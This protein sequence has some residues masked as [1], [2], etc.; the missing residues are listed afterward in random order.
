MMVNDRICLKKDSGL[1]RS[2]D[3]GAS[4]MMKSRLVAVLAVDV[5]GYS[6]LMSDNQH[7]TV[8]GL[9][10]TRDLF[11]RRVEAHGGHI[12]DF[13]GD[14]ILAVFDTVVG[15]LHAAMAAQTE[16]GSRAAEQPESRRMLLRMG[17]HVGDIIEKP[18][19][20]V[21]GDAINIAAR[22]EGLAS[23]GGIAVSHEVVSATRGHQGL[24]FHDYGEFDFKN[25]DRPVRVYQLAQK[26]GS[27]LAARSIK[28]RQRMAKGNLPK[29][30]TGLVGRAETLEQVGTMLE[31]GRLV[32]L[33]GMG[34]MG[35]TRLA[36]EAAGRAAP[37][38]P[39]GAWFAD[40]AAV[41]ETTAVTHAV[42]G[43]FGVI[44]QHGKSIEQALVDAL[45]TQRVL[46][47]LDNCEHVTQAAAGLADTLLSACPHVR[48]IAT[49]REALS[50]GGEH[51]CPLGPL[52]TAGDE[53]PAVDLFVERAQAAVPRFDPAKHRAS[54]AQICRVLDGIPL[55][56]ELAAARV[57]SL[58]PGQI[59]ARL[60]RRFSLL[61]GGSRAVRERHQTLLNAVQWSYDLLTGPERAVLVRATVF[62]GG[63]SLE[64]VEEVCTGGE[65]E[66]SDVIDILDSLVRKSLITATDDGGDVRYGM[67]ET[68]RAFGAER[69]DETEG[70]RELHCAHARFYAADADRNFA[71]WRS[72]QQRL[73]HEWLD[74]EINNLRNAFRWAVENDC[75]DIAARIGSSVG[76]LGRFRLIEEAANW[77]EQIVDRARET[78]H[79]RLTILLTWSSSSAWAFQRFDDAQRFGEE[80]I[81]LLDDPRFEP[82]VWAYGD[83]AFIAIF[84]GDIDRAIELLGL[85]AGHPADAHDRFIMAFHLF[86]MATT[87]QQ[88]EA[89][90]IADDVVAKV[91]AA[92]VPMSIGIA[93]AGKGAALE[94]VD[95]AAAL[96]AYEHGINVVRQSGARFMETLIAPRI[97]SLHARGGDSHEAL[98]GLARILESF[99]DT[100]DIASISATY[101]SLI[102]LFAR[103]GLYQAA[104][105]LNGML[106]SLVDSGG[107]MREHAEAVTQVRERLGER[108]FSEAAR[109]GAVMSRREASN[110]AGTQVQLALMTLD[111]RAVS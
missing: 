10:L 34:G 29:V 81:A 102:V 100:A 106:G 32:T 45:A 39:D 55:A 79:P 33:L 78:G 50:I 1:L 7:E 83:L 71:L 46:L 22:L 49:S 64:A 109:R 105:T 101:A 66:E 17:L 31:E 61:T 25:I 23:A 58:G 48:I 87:G 41:A 94:P 95:E 62:A 37:D 20:G 92:G 70:G 15:A 69:L 3:H 59:L 44:Q 108:V 98:T 28:A 14:A 99:G 65:I 67:L 89:R 47:I 6:R 76:D 88:H 12:A 13:A 107:L 60:D 74:A 56:I 53:A 52:G 5:V 73:A 97:A 21:Y 68:L 110:Y 36:I 40:L 90:R 54:I 93:Y 85:G 77:A 82:F 63:F 11:R 4:D 80:A 75:V 57:R 104:A 84:A 26:D 24:D 51:L 30:A 91:D 86:I 18:D 35:K 16:I 19:G 2:S 8:E 43:V 103:V 9:D 72:P 27:T 38:Y 42:A 111:S 96:A